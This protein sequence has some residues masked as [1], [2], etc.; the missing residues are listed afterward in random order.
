MSSCEILQI[1]L[2]PFLDCKDLQKINSCSQSQ[3]YNIIRVV[4]AKYPNRLTS[5]K[6]QIR[7]DDYLDTY[8]LNLQDFIRNAEIEKKLLSTEAL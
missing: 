3:A 6:S 5:F 1:L 2:K 4:R 8:S 7:T